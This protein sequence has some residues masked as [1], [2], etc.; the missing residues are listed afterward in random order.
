MLAGRYD[1]DWLAQFN[2]HIRQY[3]DDHTS[4][5]GA[6][7]YRWREHFGTDQLDSVER[8]L[9]TNPETHRA[10]LAMWSPSDDLE[11][12]SLDIPCNTHVYFDLRSDKL[13]ITVCC[14][15]NDA[16]WGCYGIDAVHFSFLQQYLAGK[17][18][19]PVGVYRQF[20][21]NFYLHTEKHGHL[22]PPG[23][24]ELCPYSRG[25]VKP[26]PLMENNRL[27]ISDLNRFLADPLGGAEY[28]NSFFSCI[29]APMYASWTDRQTKKNNGLPALQRM[30]KN[31]D[32]KLACENW[33]KRRLSHADE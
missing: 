12:P 7:G 9:K 24:V 4:L 15:S 31:N 10:V 20:S 14:R 23:Q 17:L 30:P 33:I 26:Y 16:V 29:A 21:N 1:V 25:L 28:A 18:G 13:N 32:W 27:W 11:A 5:H 19:K 6:Y 8:V 22:I 3:S 2:P